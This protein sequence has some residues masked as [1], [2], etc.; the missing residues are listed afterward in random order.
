MKKR[1][2]ALVLTLFFLLSACST[3]NTSGS[4]SPTL[5]EV[6]EPS[7]SA[8]VTPSESTTPI[9]T[10]T[11]RDELWEES[12]FSPTPKTPVPSPE[13]TPA[14]TV[15]ATPSP[16]PDSTPSPTPVVTE[17]PEDDSQEVT[18]YITKTGSKYHSD[19]CQYL[20]K[21]RIAISLDSALAKGYD[22]CSK[23]H[24]PR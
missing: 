23:C 17:P 4:P 22:P 18:V 11:P 5:D 24:P 20:R 10:K 14:P 12:S 8:T 9:V 16:T 1:F 15:N 2:L 6:P 19:G 7:F 3:L 13:I 21:S